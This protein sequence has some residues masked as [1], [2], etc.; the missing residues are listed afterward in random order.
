MK[1]N[2]KTLI[3]VI[4]MLIAGFVSVV[5]V[6]IGGME[7]ANQA[8]P[9]YNQSQSTMSTKFQSEYPKLQSD[10]RFVYAEPA[11]ILKV[12]EDGDGLVFLGFPE[13]P[14]CQ[15]LAPIADEA[16][17][18]EGLGKIYYLNIRESRTANDEVYQSLVTKL[19]DHLEKDENGEPRIYVPDVTAFRSGE[20]V[21]RFKQ[22]SAGE[23]ERVTPSTY[24]T[25]ERRKRGVEQLR[26]VI[27]QT[28]LKVH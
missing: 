15:Q 21:G 4:I 10:H 23:G 25:E 5:A 22:E 2:K 14:W 19:S 3:W 28:K 11:E 20:V 6:W 16:A 1:S 7:S 13:C 12:F 9:L 17:K 18:A 26:E 8:E 24:W 27:S